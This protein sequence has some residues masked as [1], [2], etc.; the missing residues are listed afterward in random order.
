MQIDMKAGKLISHYAH[1]LPDSNLIEVYWNYSP[2]QKTLS[3]G[4]EFLHYLL[5]QLP[6]P[7]T[8]KLDAW[9]DRL[10]EILQRV[11]FLDLVP[12]KLAIRLSPEI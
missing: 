3:F 4:H 1:Y 10:T 8:K 12:H 2:R 9:L 5:W 7:F 6:E 11:P